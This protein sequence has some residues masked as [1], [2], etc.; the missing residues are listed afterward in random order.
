[1]TK[2]GT[3]GCA[4]TNDATTKCF[5]NKI[6]MLKRTQMLQRTRMDIIYYG[7]FDYIFH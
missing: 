6:R 2:Q 3:V 5:I 7:K 4:T 1:V